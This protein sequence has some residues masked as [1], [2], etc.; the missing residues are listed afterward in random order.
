MGSPVVAGKDDRAVKAREDGKRMLRLLFFFFPSLPLRL[1]L[2]GTI[3]VVS[4]NSPPGWSEIIFLFSLR[5]SRA[6][7]AAR[8]SLAE[9]ER[10]TIRAIRAIRSLA[11]KREFTAL[12]CNPRP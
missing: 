6:D 2:S 8:I 12:P 11:V 5:G 1:S 9:S 4:R 7:S 3:Y 10:G